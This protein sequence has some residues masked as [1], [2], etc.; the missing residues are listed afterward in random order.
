MRIDT[1]HYLLLDFCER[2]AHE[3]MGILRINLNFHVTVFLSQEFY[4]VRAFDKNSQ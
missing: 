4:D 1:Y 3:Q 2:N